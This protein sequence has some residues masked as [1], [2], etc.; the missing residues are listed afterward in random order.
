M[1]RHNPWQQMVQRPYQ[2]LNHRWKRRPDV[3]SNDSAKNYADYVALSTS[4]LTYWPG[5]KWEPVDP[6]AKETE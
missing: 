5:Q 4:F 2:G 1:R 6:W 3:A